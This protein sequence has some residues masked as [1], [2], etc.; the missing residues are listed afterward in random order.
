MLNKSLAIFLANEKVRA[1]SVA[2]NSM[3]KFYTYKTID[4]TIKVG[5]TVLVEGKNGLTLVEVK[6]V[7]IQDTL[8]FENVNI[9]YAWIVQKVDKEAYET[10]KEKEQTLLKEINNLVLKGKKQQMLE[11][12]KANN[13]DIKSLE[14]LK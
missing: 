11:I 7:D 13:V 12:L 5:D 14:N 8:D 4:E 6:T 9:E 1:I 10:L 3:G 2:F